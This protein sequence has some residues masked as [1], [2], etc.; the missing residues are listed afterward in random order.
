[1]RH[2]LSVKC[3][4]HLPDMTPYIVCVCVA[5]FC[6][7]ISFWFCPF[8]PWILVQQPKSRSGPHFQAGGGQVTPTVMWHSLASNKTMPIGERRAPVHLWQ[9]HILVRSLLFSWVPNR[10]RCY[11]GGFCM[12]PCAHP[13]P[14]THT[15]TR[16]HTP[17]AFQ[18]FCTTGVRDQRR[19]GRIGWEPLLQAD[20][21]HR[22]TT[23]QFSISIHGPSFRFTSAGNG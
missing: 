9:L 8:F 15:L 10:R 21:S 11:Q 6:W 13:H 16:T 14:P 22:S 1:M 7:S 5:C 2:L 3:S 4:S 20:L 18:E 23:L 12:S 19:L 17:H